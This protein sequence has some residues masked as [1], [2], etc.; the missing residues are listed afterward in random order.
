VRFSLLPCALPSCGFVRIS[1]VNLSQKNLHHGIRR[2]A[3]WDMFTFLVTSHVLTYRGS[4]RGRIIFNLCGLQVESDEARRHLYFHCPLLTDDDRRRTP[5]DRIG[6]P[7]SQKPRWRHRQPGSRY[8][9]CRWD[10]CK[11]ME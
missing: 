11:D 1:L 3:S 10:T 4:A 9:A 6:S 7:V 8:S 5:R 2:I